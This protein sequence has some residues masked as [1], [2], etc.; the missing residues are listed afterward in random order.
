[1]FLLLK[2]Q[3]I[4]FTYKNMN[5]T[6][7]LLIALVLPFS[8]TANGQTDEECSSIPYIQKV[9]LQILHSTTNGDGWTNKWDLTAP[10]CEWHGVTITNGEVTALNLNNNNLT[11]YVPIWLNYLESLETLNLHG[12]NFRRSIPASICDLT[13]LKRL[14]L[15]SSNLT[16]KIPECICNL[17]NLTDLSLSS[18]QLEGGIPEC[19]GELSALK[20]LDLSNNNLSGNLPEGLGNLENLF[21]LHLNNNFLSGTIPESLSGL[22]S[23]IVM[24]L[25]MNQLTGS[26][27][28]ALTQIPFLQNLILSNNQLSGTIPSFSQINNLTGLFLENNQLSG[29]IPADLSNLVVL[30]NLKLDNNLLKGKLPEELSSLNQLEIFTASNNQLNGCFPKSYTVFC[31]KDVDFINN[32]GI[33]NNGDFTYFCENP[34]VE[35]VLPLKFE[36]IGADKECYNNMFIDINIIQGTAPFFISIAQ[37][38]ARV[39]TFE[40]SKSRLP[41]PASE[42]GTFSVTITDAYGSRATQQITIFTDCQIVGDD[43]A[44]SRSK[45]GT[46]ANNLAALDFQQG[47]VEV[48]ANYPNPFT[49]GTTLPFVLSDTQDLNINIVNSTGQQVYQLNQSFEAGNHQL[50]LEE[51]IFRQP[52]L[53]IYY[54][55]YGDKLISGKLIKL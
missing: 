24:N 17:T 38:G 50:Q 27:P 1:M 28:L 14:D 45:V 40:I 41:F 22:I 4:R 6:K 31:G 5:W 44:S 29:N 3:K 53:Y 37:N 33:L 2:S 43:I 20:T 21:L 42:S 48:F 16:G 39:P 13:N 55:Q 49:Q 23:V 46:P 34:D 30:N 54:V 11:G 8:F 9:I 36:L 32:L 51:N 12:N 25:G 7:I 10:V 15:S 26:I 19:I 18:N 52:G 47:S 35:C